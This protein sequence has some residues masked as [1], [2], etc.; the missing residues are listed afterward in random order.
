MDPKQQSTRPENWPGIPARGDA[1]E[2]DEAAV[3]GAQRELEE[4]VP[5]Q[6]EA[7]EPDEEKPAWTEGVDVE[8]TP[9]E[10]P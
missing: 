6:R 9:T 1:P 2:Q 5:R 10:P 7:G 4:E 3:T 8:P